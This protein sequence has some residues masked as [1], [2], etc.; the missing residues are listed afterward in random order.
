MTDKTKEL[1]QIQ[2]SMLK[3]TMKENGVMFAFAINKAYVDNSKLCFMG[4]EQYLANGKNDG[5]SAS[6]TELNNGLI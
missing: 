3:Q 5:F 2:L 1:L 6:L 4:K